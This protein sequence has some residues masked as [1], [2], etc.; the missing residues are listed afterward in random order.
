[1]RNV[2]IVTILVLFAPYDLFGKSKDLS[3]EVSRLL[4]VMEERTLSSLDR[5]SGNL[6]QLQS[7]LQDEVAC[8]GLRIMDPLTGE[9]DVFSQGQDELYQYILAVYKRQAFCF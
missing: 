7:C 8:N 4:Q 1:M 2:W 3:P 6:F 9:T 5:I